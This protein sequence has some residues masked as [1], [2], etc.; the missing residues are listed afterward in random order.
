MGECIN[1][2]NAVDGEISFIAKQLIFHEI[3]LTDTHDISP[4]V[5]FK[6]IL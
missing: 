1:C 4:I 5:Y 2:P 6:S 3:E